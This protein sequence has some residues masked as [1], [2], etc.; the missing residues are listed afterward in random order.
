MLRPIIGIQMI[1]VTNVQAALN[2]VDEINI[3]FLLSIIS[4][5]VKHIHYTPIIFIS[6]IRYANIQIVVINILK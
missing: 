4:N 6:V 1:N 5:I 3:V 2:D